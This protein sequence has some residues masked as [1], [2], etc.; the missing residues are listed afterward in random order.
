MLKI[1][2]IIIISSLLYLIVF[3][4]YIANAT[5]N[6]K[7]ETRQKWL[8]TRLPST[9]TYPSSVFMNGARISTSSSPFSSSF[10][11]L[12]SILA[13]RASSSLPPYN[14]P[15]PPPPMPTPP[16]LPPATPTVTKETIAVAN[17]CQF[18]LDGEEFDLSPLALKFGQPEYVTEDPSHQIYKLNVCGV[19]TTTGTD[20][21]RSNGMICQY[22]N[23]P[24]MELEG[25]IS[26]W[27]IAPFGQWSFID[28]NN[29][30]AGVKLYLA[31]GD[32][33]M[34][35][36]VKRARETS[37]FFPC[38][39]SIQGS[40]VGPIMA[41]ETATCTYIFTIPTPHS[42]LDAA[43]GM[44]S[45]WV[46]I[47]MLIFGS[48]VYI[49]LGCAY[50]RFKGGLQ[51]VEAFPNINFWRELPSLVQDG[52]TFSSNFATSHICKPKN[53]GDDL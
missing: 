49:V 6:E 34:F 22:R 35:R 12:A 50:N 10:P 51:G 4:V 8:P 1:S 28:E 5:Q 21:Q 44:S 40:A 43:G 31:N 19:T 36:G 14:P 52:I 16:P 13:A 37:V 42:C 39:K 26:R 46:F 23:G 7:Q 15:P 41:Q 53:K 11:N 24:M 33:C 9:G 30:G 17:K 18:S 48:A 32:D 25:V 29:R 45:G 3:N 20:C 2:I 27:N 47:I 38:D